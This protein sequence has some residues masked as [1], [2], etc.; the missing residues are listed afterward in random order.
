MTW[1]HFLVSVAY[2][3]TQYVEDP[4]SM[5]WVLYLCFLNFQDF[6]STAA[7]MANS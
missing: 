5:Y 2:F 7:N 4:S 3:K 6:E 1:T